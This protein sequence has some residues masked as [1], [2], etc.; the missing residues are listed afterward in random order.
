MKILLHAVVLAIAALSP[1]PAHAQVYEFIKW[2]KGNW[3]TI[4]VCVVVEKGVER[5]VE[6]SI[7]EWWTQWSKGEG[8][9]APP[10]RPAPPSNDQIDFR[11]LMKNYEPLKSRLGQ[12]NS[13]L[14]GSVSCVV[15]T[16]AASCATLPRCRWAKNSCQLDLGVIF[17]SPQPSLI[18]TMPKTNTLQVAPKSANCADLRDKDACSLRWTACRWDA[19]TSYCMSNALSFQGVNESCTRA[20]SEASC[21]VLPLCQWSASSCRSLLYNLGKGN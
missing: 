8:K 11:T 21:N 17:G 19:I 9:T 5:V 3:R 15:A 14:A 6:K 16:T 13:L 7:D 20:V 2:C 1:M 10:A 12:N 4:V 18:G